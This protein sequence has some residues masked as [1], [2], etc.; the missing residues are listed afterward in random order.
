[1]LYLSRKVGESIVINNAIELTVVEIKGKTAKLGI[2][3]PPDV[4]VLRKEIHEKITEANQIA[5]QL[6]GEDDLL[7]AAFAL[8]AK[9]PS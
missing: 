5:S 9:E 3:F 7:D 4:T 2:K 1:M 8:P 6:V